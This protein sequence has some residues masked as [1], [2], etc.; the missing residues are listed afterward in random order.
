MFSGIN[1][2][3]ETKAIYLFGIFILFFVL[4]DGLISYLLPIMILKHGISKTLMGAILSVAAISGAIFDFVIYKIFK[5]SVYRRILIIMLFVAALYLITVWEAETFLLY[6]LAM[7]FW[8][9]Y[10]DLKNFG[11]LDFVSRYSEKKETANNFGIIQVFQSLGYLLA[12]LLAGFLLMD[13]IEKPFAVALAF[14]LISALTLLILIFSVRKKKQNIPSQEACRENFAKEFSL[15]KKVGACILPILS[16]SLFLTIIDSFFMTI[17]PVFAETLPMG[18][19]DGIFM[20]AYYLPALIM[21]GIV[22]K[23]VAKLGEK[24]TIITGLLL[25][26]LILSL[27]FVFNTPWVLVAIIFL[28]SCF[29]SIVM[30]TIHGIY[31]KCI[32]QSP[33]FKKEIQE[34]S[35][36]FA[37]VGYI[38]GPIIAGALSDKMGIVGAFS[39]LGA[40]GLVVA[41][42]FLFLMPK[43][44]ENYLSC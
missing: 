3:S 26:S 39:I 10:F 8:G 1:D 19:F 36:F 4:F 18:S 9:F 38:V 42:I 16:L 28:S 44:Q 32:S 24:K 30:P 2:K 22:G 40:M 34:L 20:F 33:N 41:I 15:W 29:I 23:I 11:T 21:G 13:S 6:I 7:I 31:A 35:D 43:D 27:F 37:N 14:L 12:P 25:G 5:N 17:G